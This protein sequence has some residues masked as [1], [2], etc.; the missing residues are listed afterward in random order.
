MV[1]LKQ[2]FLLVFCLIMLAGLLLSMTYTVNYNTLNVSASSVYAYSGAYSSAR[3]MI[4]IETG[5]NGVIYGKNYSEKLAEAST[6]KIATAITVIDNCKN[7]DEIVTVTKPA[8]LVEGTSIYLRVGEKLSVRDLLYGLMLQSG[9]DA[10]TAL[11]IHVG[12]SVDGFAKLMNETAVKCGALNTNFVNPHGLDNPNHYTTAYDLAL[13][14]SYALKNKDFKE[15]VSSKRRQI[16]ATE[17]NTARTLIN[18]NRLLGSL[19]GCVGVKTGYTSKAGRCLVT[20]CSRGGFEFVCVVLNCGPMFEESEELINQAYKEYELYT[21]LPDYNFIDEVS[22][23]DGDKDSVKLYNKDG[24][25]IV[26]KKGEAENITVKYNYPAV[27]EA[28]LKKDQKVGTAEVFMS[29]NLIFTADIYTIEQ[30][31]SKD[32]RDK[33]KDMLDKWF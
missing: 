14:T 6:T 10:A 33:I 3:S 9:N 16:P 15:I 17:N 18:K 8:T 27:L 25:K 2:K 13:I 1:S 32:I 7:L 21:V 11:A 23:L 12:G 29:G 24:Y 31:E 20:A 19:N 4:V 5:S 26:L 28:P 22:V 30:A